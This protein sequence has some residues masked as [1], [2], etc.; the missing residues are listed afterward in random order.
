MG[1]MIENIAHQ[2]NNISVI[3][4]AATDKTKKFKTF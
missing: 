2:W 3:S 4:T 1:E